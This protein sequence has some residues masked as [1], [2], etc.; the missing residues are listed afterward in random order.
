[1][2]EDRF[3]KWAQSELECGYSKEDIASTLIDDNAAWQWWDDFSKWHRN[4]LVELVQMQ[5][6]SI[7]KKDST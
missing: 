5:I 2:I 6:K 3:R 7:L 4:E 1:M